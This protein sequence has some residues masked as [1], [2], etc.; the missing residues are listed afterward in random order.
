[1]IINLPF[2]INTNM[3]LENLFEYTDSL[4]DVG[5][6]LETLLPSKD[7]LYNIMK[8]KVYDITKPF[9]QQEWFGYD[10]N[11]ENKFMKLAKYH[12]TSLK[13]EILLF[14]KDNPIIKPSSIKAN[15]SQTVSG[16]TGHTSLSTYIM[17]QTINGAEG[18]IRISD[19]KDMNKRHKN[20]NIFNMWYMSWLSASNKEKI[21]R[22]VDTIYN[23]QENKEKNLD[24]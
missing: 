11:K 5:V 24:K 8:E 7:T 3:K 4:L 17:F 20:K 10:K 14:L 21:T 1:M 19:H 23:Y 18:M 2:L 6:L 15:I 13:Y 22:Y 16:L 12:M 9:Y